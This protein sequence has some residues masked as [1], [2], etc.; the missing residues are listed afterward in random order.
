M[1]LQ[2]MDLFGS[3]CWSTLANPLMGSE[4][5]SHVLAAVPGTFALVGAYA[6][7][8]T[9]AAASA[10]NH[11]PHVRFDDRVLPI[12]AAYLAGMAMARLQ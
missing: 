1:R 9:E 12:G 4:D 5:C 8:V 10:P 11:S 7:E 2:E 3:V 6:T